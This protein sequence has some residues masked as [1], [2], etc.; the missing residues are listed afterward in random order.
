MNTTIDTNTTETA[1]PASSASTAVTSARPAYHPMTRDEANDF[2]SENKSLIHAVLR[3]YKG[4]DEYDDLF[5]VASIGFYKGIMSY[6]PSQ[7]VKMTT[8]C[9]ECAKNEVKMHLRKNAAKSRTAAV[10]SLDG[11]QDPDTGRSENWLERNLA[12][13]DPFHP[14]TEDIGD[15]IGNKEVFDAAMRII[16]EE[17]S[18]EEQ[19]VLRRFMA[20]QPQSVTATELGASQAKVSK[21]QKIAI[22]KLTLAMKERNLGPAAS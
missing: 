19:L 4:C 9:Y 22:A 16:Q 17:M 13:N 20:G 12:E 11:L 6:D 1:A 8:Y 3:S 15:T 14:V 21:I 7:R 2:I 5:Q 18:W 10:V